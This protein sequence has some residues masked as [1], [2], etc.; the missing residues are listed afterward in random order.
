[1]KHF[2]IHLFL[3]IAPAAVLAQSDDSRRASSPATSLA[4]AYE[5]EKTQSRSAK[6]SRRTKSF[7]PKTTVD[8]QREYYER[9]EDVVKARRKAERIMKKPQ[10]S[11]PLYFGHKRPPKKHSAKKMRFCRECGIRH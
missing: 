9:V 10:Y 8:L 5:L 6:K 2:L 11:N 7:A 1:M 3:A 4:P